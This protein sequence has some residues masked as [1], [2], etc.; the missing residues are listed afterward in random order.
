MCEKKHNAK[1][2]LTCLILLNFKSN[3]HFW[4]NH[5]QREDGRTT[6]HKNHNHAEVIERIAMLCR[7]ACFLTVALPFG[8]LLPNKHSC[9]KYSCW[10]YSCWKYSCWKYSCWG[11]W[12]DCSAMQ[13]CMFLN[14]SIFLLVSS[15]QKTKHSC[16]KNQTVDLRWLKGLQCH[17]DLHVS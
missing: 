2:F 3:L 16:W 5:G 9:W 13:I 6:S 17:A 4:S 10:K 8:Q 1:V 15:F 12:K 11:D 14:C 7:F